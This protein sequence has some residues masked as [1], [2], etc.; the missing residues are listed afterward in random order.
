MPRC[1]HGSA[2]LG[3]VGVW[4]ARSGP[5]ASCGRRPGRA[6]SFRGRTVLQAY[7]WV[8]LDDQGVAVAKVGG[9]VYDRYTRF[10]GSADP[11]V[12]Y[13]VEPGPAMGLAYVV[14]PARWRQGVGRAVLRAAVAHPDVANVRVFSAGI[15]ADNQASR[16]CASS[17][18][19]APDV[20]EPDWEGSVYYLLR[21]DSVSAASGP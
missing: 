20:E 6:G 10:D 15:D 17:A 16:R 12:V 13:A 2:T 14:H 11:P 9:E 21:R 18:G 7:L 3:C 19:F 5:R 4:A 1:S 8:A